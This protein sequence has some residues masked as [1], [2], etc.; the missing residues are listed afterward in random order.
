MFPSRSEIDWSTWSQLIRELSLARQRNINWFSDGYLYGVDSI[1]LSPKSIPDIEEINNALCHVGWE[2]VYVEGMIP[3]DKYVEMQLRKILPIT[4]SIRDNSSIYY[5]V[6]PDFIHDLM[7]HVCMM[8]DESFRLLIEEWT[9][10]H[11][12][13]VPSIIELEAGQAT[14]ELVEV[15]KCHNFDIAKVD[16]KRSKWLYLNQLCDKQKSR[17]ALMQRFYAWAIEFGILLA[18]NH[19]KLLGTA[20][21]SSVFE[22]N[23]I[24]NN[25]VSLRP[26]HKE[27][28]N[29]PADYSRIQD[30]FFVADSFEEY[31]DVLQSI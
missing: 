12:S 21:L 20:S 27:A 25:N 5:S 3:S 13:I 26:F 2:A 7:G 15:S 23:R 31:F 22:Q 30:T 19:P 9:R 6:T 29:T 16:E 4:F 11:V 14:V 1:S 10:K 17:F 24:F 8:F 18:D 28:L